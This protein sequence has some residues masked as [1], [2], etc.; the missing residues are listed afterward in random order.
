MKLVVNL[1]EQS[2]KINIM[3]YLRRWIFLLAIGLTVPFVL[4]SCNDEEENDD[5]KAT[6]NFKMTDAPIDNSSVEAVFVTV[7]D[8]KVDGS[9]VDGFQ[10]QT[11]DLTAYQQGNAKLMASDEL[12][13][14][15]YNNISLVLDYESDDAG[16]SPGCYIITEDD[17]K[18]NL[19]ASSQSQ[20]EITIND[21]FDVQSAT[22]N[23][24]VIDFDLRKSIVSGNESHSESD[25]SFVTQNEM[26]TALRAVV[27]SEAGSIQG[28]AANESSADG[29]MV[30]YVYNKGEFDSTTE[31]SGQG[32]SN[33]MFANAVTSAKVQGDGSY[34]LS[35]LQ[36]G[37]YEVHVANYQENNEGELEFQGTMQ[38]SSNTS[39]YLLGG[40]MVEANTQLTIDLLI[41]GIFK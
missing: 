23:N 35:F 11:I 33:V 27:E 17:M 37:E 22:E 13:V 1:D 14:Q 26:N 39:G 6:V 30:V 28:Q 4:T 19:N 2:K 7:A 3:N 40:I 20:G 12:D 34:T 36:E 16:N 31:T 24:V 9:S 5:M 29:Q 10:K 41:S 15:S 32:N 8:L 25:F 18:H 21:G 38:A